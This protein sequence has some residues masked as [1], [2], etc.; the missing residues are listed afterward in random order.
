[1]FFNFC[2]PTSFKKFSTPLVLA[3]L[4]LFSILN[5]YSNT[6]KLAIFGAQKRTA[7]LETANLGAYLCS[8]SE[9]GGWTIFKSPLF[10]CKWGLSFSKSPLFG[11]FVNPSISLTQPNV[12]RFSKFLRLCVA[13][14]PKN[15]NLPCPIWISNVWNSLYDLGPPYTT[16]FEI[17]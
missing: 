4:Q 1:M 7:S 3:S 17:L 6:S 14:D 11:N 15:N 8:K 16:S 5:L 12:V 10:R 9:K 13:F 2:D